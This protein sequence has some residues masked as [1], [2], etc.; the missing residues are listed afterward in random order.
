MEA[1]LSAIPTEM[2]FRRRRRRRRK[3][4]EDVFKTRYNIERRERKKERERERERDREHWSFEC[5]KTQTRTLGE[6]ISSCKYFYSDVFFFSKGNFRKKKEISPFT[7]H[8][9]STQRANNGITTT[10]GTKSL[11]KHHLTREHGNR[12]RIFRLRREFH[13]VPARFIPTVDV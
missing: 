1:V 12:D 3:N 4:S 10:T 8:R 9:K 13:L 6:S 11:S 2:Y 7:F 5:C